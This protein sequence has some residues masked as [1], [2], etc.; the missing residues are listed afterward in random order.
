MTSPVF[1]NSL[2]NSCV[3]LSA[4]GLFLGIIYGVVILLALE[5]L[6]IFKKVTIK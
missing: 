4:V 2:I 5:I 6:D 1:I 3:Q